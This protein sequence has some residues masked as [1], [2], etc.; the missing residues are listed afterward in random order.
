MEGFLEEELI[1]LIVSE[2]AFGKNC[3][4]ISFKL[5]NCMTGMKEWWYRRIFCNIITSDGLHYSIMIKLKIQDLVLREC[6]GCDFMF[7]NELIFYEKI[8]PFL[9]ECRGP[10]VNDA[11]ALF[12]PRFFYG[13][14]KCSKLM[15]NDLIV[16]ENVITLGFC[17]SNDKVFLDYEH[18]TIALQ[19]I[20]K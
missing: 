14:N 13:R 11:H 2:G 3:N 16:I 15:S 9:L 1:N 6:F 4:L 5:Y 12:L 18:L 7:D 19:T 10:T 20:A 8:V 17:L